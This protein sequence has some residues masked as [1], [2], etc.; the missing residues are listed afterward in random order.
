MANDCCL[1]RVGSDH[2]ARCIA[3][4]HHGNIVR[5]AKLQ[6]PS[7]FIAGRG[8]DRAAQMFR[9]VGDETEGTALNPNERGDHSEPEVVP[10]FEDGVL[11]RQKLNDIPDVVNP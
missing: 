10:Q 8:I 1:L 7:R 6:E 9:I 5:I 11:I 3:E 2:E 4:R